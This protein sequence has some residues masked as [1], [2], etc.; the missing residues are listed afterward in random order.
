MI[1]FS[2]DDERA[3]RFLAYS[4]IGFETVDFSGAGVGRRLAART[5]K[6]RSTPTLILG[7][8]GQRKC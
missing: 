4:G 2:Q 1:S 3:K 7:E 8:G 5:G 6:V